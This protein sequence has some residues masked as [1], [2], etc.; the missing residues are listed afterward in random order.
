M[1]SS[2]SPWSS[3]DLAD[4]SQLRVNVIIARSVDYDGI[5]TGSIEVF[6]RD[7][8][9]KPVVNELIQVQ[10]NGRPLILSND[11]SNYF[12]PYPHYRLVDP[13]FI[14]EADESYM[15]IVSLTDGQAY[16]LGAIETLP[17]ITPAQFS[18][19]HRHSRQQALTLTWHQ[20]E[21]QNWL[22]NQWKRWQGETS[23]TTLKIAKSNWT[24]DLWNTL[25][26]EPGNTGKADYLVI[27]IGA[28]DEHYTIP[29]SYFEGP[30]TRFTNLDLQIDSE[31]NL[32]VAKPFR[33]GSVISSVNTTLYRIEMTD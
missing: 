13:T 12:G 14:V 20:L 5:P 6:I 17:A 4:P 3:S 18:P 33:E 32:I 25:P 9:D 23:A 1:H 24:D 7:E 26:P 30:L 16:T 31:K 2:N 29:L 11:S 22:T 27:P 21:P 19:P 28:G 15:V 8:A 10:V